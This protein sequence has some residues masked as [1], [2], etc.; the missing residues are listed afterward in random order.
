TPPAR[1]TMA[2]P[3]VPSSSAPD[4]RT[5]MTLRYPRQDL[6]GTGR[7]AD[8]HDGEAFHPVVMSRPPPRYAGRARMP[9]RRG[10]HGD[11]RLE[12]GGDVPRADLAQEERGND[13]RR[14][15]GPLARAARPHRTRRV[16]ASPRLRR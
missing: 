14:V 3:M 9:G 15:P 2:M 5:A 10:V 4:K 12:G 11:A 16:S 1:F 8:H 7:S 13:H 6:D